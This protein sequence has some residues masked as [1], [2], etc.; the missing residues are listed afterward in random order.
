[1]TRGLF[2]NEGF[3]IRFASVQR[4]PGAANPECPRGLKRESRI[5]GFR[6][7]PGCSA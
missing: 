5:P 3:H 2:L 6:W 1:M 7:N 4:P